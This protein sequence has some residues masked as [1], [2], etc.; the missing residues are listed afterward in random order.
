MKTE[1]TLHS[2]KAPGRF[3]G[4]ANFDHKEYKSLKSLGINIDAMVSASDSLQPTQTQSSIAAPIQ[5]L[6]HW[7]PGH[8]L[9]QT[10]AKKIDM[11]VGLSIVGREE[12]EE[13]VQT[14]M[15]YTGIPLPYNDFNNTPLSSWNVS[16][17]KRTVVRFE[18][19]AQ[20]GRL[21][22]LRTAAANIDS[23]G[24]KRKAAG[25]ALERVRN[26]IG[27]YGYNN[28]LNRTYGFLNDPFLLPYIT[29][30]TKTAGGT[31][32]GV[33]TALEITTDFKTLFS[34][35]RVQSGDNIGPENQPILIAMATSV[36]DQLSTTTDESLGVTVMKWL[37][38]TYPTVSVMSAPELDAANG[39]ENVLYMYPLGVDDGSTDDGKVFDQLVQVKFQSNGSSVNEK[40]VLIENY[41]NAMA[42]ILLKRPLDVVRMTG[43]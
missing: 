39:G 7:L 32:W 34:E 11:A 22:N 37:K 19:G 21:E 10:K 36:Y 17:E 40:N 15:E 31:T 12:D 25:E 33:A 35:L 13:I 1:S 2:Y 38:D 41:S 8:V 30:S 14:F 42:G 28:G 4:L 24:N 5:F 43:I 9:Y 26:T 6:Q 27:W 23:M 16:Y 18:E 29:A 3:K 20:L